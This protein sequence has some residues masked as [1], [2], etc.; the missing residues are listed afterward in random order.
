MGLIIDTTVFVAAEKGK[1]DL[2]SF[3]LSEANTEFAM[4]AVS[5][6]EL[7][8]GVLRGKPSAAESR[9]LFVETILTRFPVVSFDLATARVHAQLSAKLAAMGRPVGA[10]DLIIAATAI[11]IDYDV[12]SFDQR[13]FPYI[14]GIRFRSPV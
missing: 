7:L 6:S 4:S 1:F 14:P 12:L 8:V 10:H 5:A 9:R 11:A 2:G 3:L 13:S